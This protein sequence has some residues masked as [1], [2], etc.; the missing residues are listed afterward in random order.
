MS[1]SAAA[2]C[3][4]KLMNFIKNVSNLEYERNIYEM[5]I[6]C[7]YTRKEITQLYSYGCIVEIRGVKL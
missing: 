6:L 7:M 3:S 2:L 1:V 5:H 4:N